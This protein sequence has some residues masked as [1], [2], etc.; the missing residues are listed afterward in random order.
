M[1]G[2]Y[3][4]SK[5]VLRLIVKDEAY[6]HFFTFWVFLNTITLSLNA[7]GTSEEMNLFLDSTNSVFTWIFIMELFLKICG[8]G[9]KKYCDDTMNYMDGFIVLASIVELVYTAMASD[10]G[11]L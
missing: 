7:Y 4:R 3:K 5:F 11:G 1:H 2:I 10:E 8:I 6:D 9:I